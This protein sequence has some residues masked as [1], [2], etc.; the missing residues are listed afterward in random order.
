MSRMPSRSLHASARYERGFTLIE[1]LMV[2]LIAGI[3]AAIGVP[4]L[5][6]GSGEAADQKAEQALEGAMGLAEADFE[7]HASY[8]QFKP[9]ANITAAYRRYQWTLGVATTPDWLAKEVKPQRILVPVHAGAR[10]AVCDTNGF[11][12]LCL[13]HIHA[14]ESWGASI[15]GTVVALQHAEATFGAAAKAQ[16][17]ASSAEEYASSTKT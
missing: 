7:R 10:I 4:F 6:Q 8:A 5:L 11:Y 16:H 13:A 1:V 12:A 15:E 14:Q 17:F 9:E 3:L 2:I